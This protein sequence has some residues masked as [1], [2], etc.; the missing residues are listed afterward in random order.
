MDFSASDFEE[1]SL[2]WVFRRRIHG[3]DMGRLP[4]DEVRKFLA[5]DGPHF[6]VLPT[7]LAE[8]LYPTLPSGYR[9]FSTRGFNLAKGRRVNL[10]LILKNS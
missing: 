5:A 8:R 1:P 4:P 2:V 6:V 3:Y 10:T 9:K 7:P